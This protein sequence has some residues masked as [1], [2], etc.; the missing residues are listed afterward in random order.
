MPEKNAKFYLRQLQLADKEE[1]NWRERAEKVVKTYR[2]EEKDKGPSRFNILWSNTETQ[3][4]A[5]YSATPK[6]DVRRRYKHDDEIGRQIATILDRALQYS[7]DSGATYD[8][9]RTADKLVLDFLLPGRMVSRV[10][11]HP[12]FKTRQREDYYDT[13]EDLDRD[14]GEVEEREDGTFVYRTSYDELVTEEVRC[15]EVPWKYYRQS[16]ADCWD[17]V[18]WVAY[19]DNFLTK[20]EIIEQFGKEH[21]DVPLNFSDEDSEKETDDEIKKAQVWELWDKE[22]RKVVAVIEG[23]D[24][25][26]MEEDDPLKL[27]S[28][29]PQP[30]P[31][32]IVESPNSLIP[33]PEYT[34]YQ[35]QAEEL[36]TISERIS[37][38]TEAM[39]A[40]GFYPGEDADKINKLLQEK[41]NVL[42]AVDDWAA[43]AEKGGLKGVIDWWPIKEIAEVWYRLVQQRDQI[44]NAIYQLT[45]ISDIQRGATDPRETK[46]AQQLKANFGTRRLLPKQQ[47]IQKFFRD[48]LRIKAE[49]IAEH[50]HPE[51][52]ARITATE[53][54][55]ELVQVMRD[56]ALRSFSV[57]VETDSTIAPDEEMEKQGVA[58]FLNAMSSYLQQVAPIIQAQPAAVE[59]LG[60]ILL[61][62]TR[63][64]KIARDVE[65]EVEDFINKFAQMPQRQDSEAQ[66][67]MM[68]LQKKLELMAQE[69]QAKAQLERQEMQ[70]EQARKDRESQAEI[71]R[72][73]REAQADL[74]RANVELEIKM[75]EA[76]FKEREMDSRIKGIE[77]KTKAEKAKANI[78]DAEQRFQVQRE[79]GQIEGATV[80]SDS[81][82]KRLTLVRDASGQV[83]GGEIVEVEEDDGEV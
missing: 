25:L 26:L 1:K 27:R 36:N 52:L 9:D 39:K 32:L 50:F 64:F 70:A 2:D 33:I 24:E 53:V 62:I 22:D 73:D 37:K 55:P 31:A 47:R 34:L 66:K 67:E 69:K 56:D 30:E 81:G 11:Y 65:A 40:V 23:Y 74:Q 58:E 20:E 51:T 49:I 46:A 5:L 75:R 68:E 80:N 63:K 15:Y 38:L 8:F 82:T 72:K 16:P 43:F 4:P 44:I 14:N 6:P 60:K 76:G 17:D 48:I 59:P 10:K 18:W 54:T 7:M 71:A 42:I 21:A 41:D 28:F 12:Y 35:F 78:I 61:W 13:D 19:G 83:I 3:K 29:F 77:A 57:D 79:G 45:G